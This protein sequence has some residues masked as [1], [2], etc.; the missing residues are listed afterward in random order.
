VVQ[1]AVDFLNRETGEN[2]YVVHQELQEI[3]QEHVGIIRTSEELDRGV[4]AVMG[5][6]ERV[7]GVKAHG[8]SQYNPGWHEA[9]DLAPLLTM[10][11]AVARSARVREESRGAHTRADFEGERDEWGGRNIVVS[12]AEGGMR[13][14]V[15]ERP[16]PPE[17]LK[18]IA[19]ASLEELEQSNA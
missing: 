13:V 10:S 11:E 17:E 1:L 19:F 7:R 8:A 6:R 18:A 9:L 2:P 3:M 14:R 12:K 16:P 4:E 15:I 5:L